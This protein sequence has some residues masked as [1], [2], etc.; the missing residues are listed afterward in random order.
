MSFKNMLTAGKRKLISSSA[1]VTASVGSAVFLALT[2]GLGFVPS[3]LALGVGAVGVGSTFFAS[4]SPRE[5][6]AS[7]SALTPLALGDEISDEL[8]LKLEELYEL[9]L[10]YERRESPI[11]P[12]VSGVLTNVLELFSRMS[13]RTD[14]QSARIA[15]IRYVDLL[16]KLNEALGK[17]YYLDIEAHPELWS[18]PEERMEAVET[19]LNATA[20]QILRNIRQLNS[21]RDL[22]YQLSLDKL[23]GASAEDQNRADLGIG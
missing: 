3:A 19:A 1:V 9:A 15:G 23:M 2:P 14:E 10:I 17:K 7:K 21:S 6:E 4:G 16:S 22:V 8:R 5:I 12:A 18:N 11:L 13:E 20:E